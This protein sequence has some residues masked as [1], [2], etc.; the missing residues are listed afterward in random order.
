MSDYAHSLYRY[1]ALAIP[2]ERLD[3]R[4]C[5]TLD[6]RHDGIDPSAFLY[7]DALA[8][9]SGERPMRVYLARLRGILRSAPHYIGIP[10][11]MPR[12]DHTRPR[13]A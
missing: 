4:W 8:P 11:P 3:L 12:M 10:A 13:A 2:S 1:G 6:P 7:E 9:W 5:A